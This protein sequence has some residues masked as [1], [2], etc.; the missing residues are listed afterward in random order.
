LS[1]GT[2]SDTL[3][4][5][6]T[7][8][9]VDFARAFNLFNSL[10]AFD[11]EAIPRLSLA[12][13]ITPNSTA[14]SWTIR[15]R[16]GVTWHDGKTLTADDVIY[17]LQRITNPKSPLEGASQLTPINLQQVKKLD[18]R[19]IRLPCHS[20]FS[21]LP[22]VLASN[23]FFI[24]PV[25]FNPKH[26]IGTGPFKFESF[27]PGV[28]STFARFE[29]YWEDGLPY[30]DNLVISDFSDE[31]SQVNALASDQADCID[32]LSAASIAGVQG[33]GGEVVVSDGGGWNPFTM[34]ADVPPFN[35][36][37]VREAM[38][39]IVDREQMIAHVFGGH[40]VL[41]NDVFS[42][43]DPD[44]DKSL[45][46]RHQD[47]GKAKALLRAAGHENL[48][49]QLV[50]SAVAQG[51][52][53]SAEVLAQQAAKAGV[54]VS[55]NKVTPTE[56]YGPQY[57]KWAFAQDYWVYVPYLVQV[58]QATLP[59][60]PFNECHFDDARYNMLYREA[61]ATVDSAKRKEI[62]HEMQLIDYT[63]GGYIIPYFAPIIDAHAKRLKGVHS[64]RTGLSLGNF[65]FKQ[66]WLE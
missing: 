48:T 31:T 41:G 20:P 5:Q 34:R 21:S 29:N 47:I 15:V 26:P 50:T 40:G 66:M 4:P 12:E 59:S 51:V 17:S 16:K 44:Y 55:L 7:F 57:L 24:V 54:T 10:V 11:T 8:E 49:V 35:D 1:G 9:N 45:P 52:V 63:S 25:G 22:E 65:A 36:N 53:E 19:T 27:S 39:L 37:R 64:S 60:S 62:E 18:A 61:L 58:A 23:F 56:F 33:S 43:Y 3:D 30:V 32:L 2:S 46:Q 14:T 38:R 6:N 28:Q 42:I 13:E